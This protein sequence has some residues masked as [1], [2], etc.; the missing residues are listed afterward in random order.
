MTV[1]LGE[2]FTDQTRGGEEIGKQ[3]WRGGECTRLPPT[4]PAFDFG[5]VASSRLTCLLVLYSSS[6]DFFSRFFNFFL[7]SK[8]NISKFQF[9]VMQDLPEDHF[10]VSG[11]SWVVI[12][13]YYLTEDWKRE[14]N[15]L[16]WKRNAHENSHR[17]T[18][19]R[20]KTLWTMTTVRIEGVRRRE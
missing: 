8:I 12:I 14:C 19:S 17:R 16:T 20:K 5:L 9:D 18:I 11:A 7:S 10:R 4:W 15:R 3:G 2:G 6:R 1:R 13:N